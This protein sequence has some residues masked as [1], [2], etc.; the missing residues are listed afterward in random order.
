[1]FTGMLLM[2]ATVDELLLNL[3]QR[4]CSEKLYIMYTFCENLSKFYGHNTA[5][6]YYFH[7]EVCAADMSAILA[8]IY[9][10]GL[11]KT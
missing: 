4:Y 1:M 7:T 11:K 10:K 9:S 3:Y 6:L 5:A 8:S 2:E